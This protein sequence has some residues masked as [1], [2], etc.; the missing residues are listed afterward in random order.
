MFHHIEPNPL[1]AANSLAHDSAGE[2]TPSINSRNTAGLPGCRATTSLPGVTSTPAS[3]NTR[4]PSG[5][6]LP[7]AAFIESFSTGNQNALPA[8]M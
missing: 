3:T 5:T 8:G 1:R 2:R 6:L 7:L 4:T